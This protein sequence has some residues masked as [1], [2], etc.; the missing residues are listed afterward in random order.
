MGRLLLNS[1]FFHFGVNAL[2]NLQNWWISRLF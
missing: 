2:P 1:F